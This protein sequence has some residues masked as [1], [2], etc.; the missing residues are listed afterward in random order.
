MPTEC[1]FTSAAWK[2][3]ATALAGNAQKDNAQLALPQCF[4]VHRSQP[5]KPSGTTETAFVFYISVLTS[6]SSLNTICRLVCH[7][8]HTALML[9]PETAGP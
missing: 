6:S 1:R 2:A 3:T 5:K 4:K 8:G 9:P 7:F